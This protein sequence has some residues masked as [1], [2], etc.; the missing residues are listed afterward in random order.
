M[1]SYLWLEGQTLQDVQRVVRLIAKVT[2]VREL[3]MD[4]GEAGGH[5]E[6]EDITRFIQSLA[7]EN[8]SIQ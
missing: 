1:G 2:Y 4:V 3:L 6:G 5:L 8:L 7:P